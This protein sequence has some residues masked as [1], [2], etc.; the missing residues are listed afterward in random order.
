MVRHTEWDDELSKDTKQ[1]RNN[2]KRRKVSADQAH[3]DSESKEFIKS[4]DESKGTG[5]MAEKSTSVCLLKSKKG[6][7][8]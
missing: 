6:F 5:W 1:R 4:L 3:L 2:R 7:Q 8:E